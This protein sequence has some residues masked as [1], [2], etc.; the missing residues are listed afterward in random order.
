MKHLTAVVRIYLI[1]TL[2]YFL[3]TLLLPAIKADQHAY[4]LSAGQYHA[5]RF[6]IGLP[7]AL[8]WLAAFLTYSRLKAYAA[9]MAKTA[10]GKAYEH[11]ALGSH[12][13]AWGLYVPATASLLLN[14]LANDHPGLHSTVIILLNYLSL[15][16]TFMALSNIGTGAHLLAEHAKRVYSSMSNR[17][18]QLIFVSGGVLYCYLTFRHLDLQSLGSTHNP[19]FLPGWLLIISLIIPYLYAWFIG[20]LAVFDLALTANQSRG[21]LYRQA[22]W[23][24]A[25]GWSV[26][27]AGLIAVQYLH[28]II[29]RNGHLAL[30]TVFIVTY[31]IYM[32][33]VVGFGLLI[34]GVHRLKR[35]EEV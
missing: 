10:E 17:L 2:G 6:L 5:L 4:M 11:L 12:W 22:L 18:L 25:A 7:L 26:V 16:F 3:L 32:C 14:A 28:T 35:I 1:A 13:L 31:S 19:Y 29:P 9:L 24:I 8:I 23:L 33:M 27:I 15:G 34:W 20:L 30:N 21:I